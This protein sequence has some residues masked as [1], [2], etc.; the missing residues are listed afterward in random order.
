VMYSMYVCSD[1]IE[2]QP[3][4]DI[5]APLSGIVPV[6]TA[7]PVERVNYA[8]NPLSCLP[9]LL[10]SCIRSALSFAPVRVTLFSSLQLEIT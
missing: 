3:V 9:C 1:L 8:F 10:R 2:A 7:Q 4:G 5:E 6:G